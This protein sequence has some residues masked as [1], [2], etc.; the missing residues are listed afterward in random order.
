MTCEHEHFPQTPHAEQTTHEAAGAKGSRSDAAAAALGHRQN[1][2][3]KQLYPDCHHS[4]WRHYH[5]P[6][7]CHHRH[8][9]SPHSRHHSHRCHYLR[10][11]HHLHSCHPCPCCCSASH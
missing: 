10:Y 4:H 3:S 11:L 8:H 6:H 1:L 9:Q 2:P 7:R 5:H